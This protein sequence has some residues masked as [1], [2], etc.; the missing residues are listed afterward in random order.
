MFV[1]TQ[2]TDH[3][4]VGFEN[5]RIILDTVFIAVPPRRKHLVV[6]AVL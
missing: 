2:G 6:G 3:I 4:L 5:F 1:S